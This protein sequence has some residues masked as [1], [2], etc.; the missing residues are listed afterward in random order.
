MGLYSFKFLID[1]TVL[2]ETNLDSRDKSSCQ[3]FSLYLL[4]QIVLEAR[5]RAN[6][7]ENGR[8]EHF[9]I[10]LKSI[11]FNKNKEDRISNL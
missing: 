6:L 2:L 9:I 3:Q 1:S 8:T 5:N 11:L 4:Q 7:I 10:H